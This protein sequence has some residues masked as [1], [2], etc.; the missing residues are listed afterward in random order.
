MGISTHLLEKFFNGDCTEEEKREIVEFFKLHPEKLDQ[1]LTEDSWKDFTPDTRMEVPTEKLRSNIRQEVG[2]MQ[3]PVRKIRYS[4]VAAASV[5]FLVAFYFLL[6]KGT[7]K[8][9]TAPVAAANPPKAKNGTPLKIIDNTSSAIKTCFL[10]D[11]S[12]VELTGA[13]RISFNDPFINGR[14]DIF[15]EG[16]AVFTV[17]KDDAKPF[18]VHARGIATTALGTVFRVSDKHGLFTTVHLI[19]GRVVVKKEDT[20]DGKAFK[21]IYL[22]PGQQLAVNKENFSVQIKN[23]TPATKVRPEPAAAP[24]QQILTFTNRPLTEILSLLQKEYKMSIS[25][26][27]AALQNMTFTG[28][29]DRNK[30]SLESFLNTLCDLNEL[31]LKKISDN[32]FSIQVK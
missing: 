27:A 4:W 2:E 19:S 13:S 22:L 31:T 25:F 12:K 24:A 18:T 5:I 26:D 28:T 15:L 21:N 10:P 29:L 14:R 7:N 8:G 6:H 20:K 1:Y 23:L 30:E 11:S 9:T 17:R 3:T 16:E 32:S